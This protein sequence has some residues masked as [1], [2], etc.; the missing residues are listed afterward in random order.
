MG[1]IVAF[2]N[3]PVSDELA[4]RIDKLVHKETGGSFCRGPANESPKSWGDL[5]ARY[6]TSEMR[7]ERERI[8]DMIE[9]MRDGWS[10]SYDYGVTDGRCSI[11]G[12]EIELQVDEQKFKHYGCD[13]SVIT[14]ADGDEMKVFEYKC[15]ACGS[16]IIHGE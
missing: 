9:K 2:K 1:Q 14:D 10:L 15:K 7:E 6:G 3:G 5:P 4:N 11:C 16:G 12:G 8:A 13:Y